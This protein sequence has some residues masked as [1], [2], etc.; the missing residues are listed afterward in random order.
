MQQESGTMNGRNEPAAIA[1]PRGGI[2][3]MKI[4]GVMLA[5]VL[6]TTVATVWAIKTVLFASDF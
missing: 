4:L 5:T 6:L 2:S 1:Q 3:W